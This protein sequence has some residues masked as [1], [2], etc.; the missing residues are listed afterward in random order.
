MAAA[1]LL[2]VA[3]LRAGV[4]KLADARDSKST[5]GIPHC[6][7][8]KREGGTFGA[9]ESKKLDDA[10]GTSLLAASSSDT[11]VLFA[12]STTPADVV[13]KFGIPTMRNRMMDI[14]CWFNNPVL[15]AIQAQWR[16][17]Q[18]LESHP[19]PLRRVSVQIMAAGCVHRALF[20]P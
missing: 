8:K 18:I 9:S 20:P 4:V 15:L 14:D 12:Q 6:T 10:A 3:I 16:D 5:S 7:H 2:K 13:S 17:C 1:G 11:V 19:S